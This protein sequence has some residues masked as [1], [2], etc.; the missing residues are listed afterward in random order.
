MSYPSDQTFVPTIIRA[1]SPALKPGRTRILDES[2][3]RYLYLE[4]GLTKKEIHKQFHVPLGVLDAT[5]L[6]YAETFG[7]ELRELKSRHYAKATKG[8]TR[9]SHRPSTI[10]AEDVLRPRVEAGK[11]VSAIAKELGLSEFMVRRNISM[12]GLVSNRHLHRSLQHV[13]LEM[14]ERMERFSPGLLEAARQCWEEPA[15]YY[16]HLYEVFLRLNEMIWQVQE[17]ANAYRWLRD[18]RELP[19]SDICWNRNSAEIKLA[20]ALRDAGLPHIR[21]YCY[22][23]RLTADFYLPDQ[24]LLVEV[25][26][27]IHRQ[28]TALQT[29]DKLKSQLSEQLG[30]KL[31]RVTDTEVEQNLA[32][33]VERIKSY[34]SNP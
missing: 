22:W 14:L 11:K 2:S 4:L 12:Y 25:D 15:L 7:R 13:D 10:I 31:L 21:Q 32:G 6:Y 30:Y 26:G 24:N 28:S 1:D 34:S 16:D 9:G 3:F 5:R 19:K 18:K 17:M 27:R 20:L 23:K 29:Q 33:V 8:N